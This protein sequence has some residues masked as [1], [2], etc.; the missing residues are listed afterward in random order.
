MKLTYLVQEPKIKH[1]QN[2]V[3][4]LLHGYGSNEQGLFSFASELPND[5]F[6]V[7]VRAPYDLQYNSYAWYAINFDANENKFSD[8]EQAK[9]SR[10]L[11]ADFIDELLKKY[12]IDSDNVTLIGFSQGCILSYSV[13][14]SYPE[15]INKVGAMSGYLNQEML[16]ADY[17]KY[18]LSDLKF[19]I[20][21]GTLDEVV[22]ID[23]ARK[24]KPFLD[25]LGINAVYKE[26]PMGH[27]I[28]PQNFY[29]FKQWL[30]S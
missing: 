30:D 12:A 7:S 18:N 6:I 15:K 10:D 1:D 27:G 4:I 21:Y 5:C 16:T 28:S 29:D 20:S 25:N 24:A 26:Y 13:A 3:L 19:F 2:P 9:K 23:W 22:P 14:L 8:V 17:L 11:L